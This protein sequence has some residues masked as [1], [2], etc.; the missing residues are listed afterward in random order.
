MITPKEIQ[1]Q[2]LTWWKDVLL[3]YIDENLVD[4]IS[5]NVVSFFPREINR[6]G[7]ISA[8]DVQNKVLEH[9]KAIELLQNH[10]KNEAKN[11]TKES[12]KFGYKLVLEETQF[13]KI[14]KQSVPTKI[15]IESIKDYLKITNK[16]KEYQIFQRNYALIL[17]ELPL[18]NEWINANTNVLKLIEHNTWT[19]TLKVCKY[20]IATPKPQLYIRQL[21]ID[22]HTKYIQENKSIITSLLNFLIINEIDTNE[23]D[24]EKRFNLLS[25]EQLIRI[26]FLDV[27]KSPLPNI[28]DIS[29]TEKE[30]KN[31]YQNYHLNANFQFDNI[32]IT[33]NLMNFLTLPKLKNTIAIWSGGGFNISYLKN[34]DWLKEKQFYYWGDIDAQG[35][36]I[37]NQCRSYFPNVIA[38]M[39]DKETLENFQFGEGTPAK[40]QVLQHLSDTEKMLYEY[41]KLNNIRL[42]QE[43]IT[44]IFAEA[45]IKKILEFVV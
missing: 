34:I 35:F 25:R 42:E 26:R 13:A 5:D 23:K 31:Y 30:L 20:F 19:D 43:K 28:T 36:Q 3:A 15:I 16:E 33:E 6:I 8:K 22:V 41:L 45:E 29:F 32:F 1:K 38:V 9:K 11:D 4:N 21:P 14:G 40:N 39:M 24:F 12:K 17:K 18:L 2:C 27:S 37:L 10:S 7:K 44:Q